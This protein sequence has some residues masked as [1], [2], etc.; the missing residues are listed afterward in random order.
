MVKSPEILR[1]IESE[2]KSM[3]AIITC[4]IGIAKFLR[5]Y[6]KPTWISETEI[7]V[8]QNTLGTFKNV[9]EQFA[10]ITKKKQLLGKIK[11]T[12]NL[13][14]VWTEYYGKAVREYNAVK[15]MSNAIEA[16]H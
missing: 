16:T 15:E 9:Q 7:S 5:R 8:K 2:I 10:F 13:I 1:H 4:T 11:L 6:R 14:Q 12:E 3:T